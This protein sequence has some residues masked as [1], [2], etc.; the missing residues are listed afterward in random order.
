MKLRLIAVE[1]VSQ[2]AQDGEEKLMADAVL[3]KVRM[4]EDELEEVRMADDDLQEE[5]KTKGCIVA[6]DEDP[7]YCCL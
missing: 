5:L 7:V 6:E 3:E 1:E 4:D 2:E